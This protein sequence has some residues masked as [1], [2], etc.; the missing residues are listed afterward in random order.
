MTTIYLL[1]IKLL[2]DV[3]FRNLLHKNYAS[4]RGISILVVA[5]MFLVLYVLP[6][7]SV[8]LI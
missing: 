6:L 2:R 5:Y 8:T 1:R 7:L 3:V 4:M